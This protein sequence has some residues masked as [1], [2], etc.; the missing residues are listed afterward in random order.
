MKLPKS[1]LEKAKIVSFSPIPEGVLRQLIITYAPDIKFD[2]VVIPEFDREKILRELEDADIVVGDYTFKIPITREMIEHMKRVRLIQ[3][4]STGYDHIDVEAAKEKGIPVANIGGANALSVAEHTIALA[5]LLLKRIIHAHHRVSSGVW[6]QDEMFNLGIYELY[7]KKWGI[8]GLGRIGREV[9]KRVRCFGVKT[10]YYDKIRFPVELER[11]LQVEYRPLNRLLRESDVISIHVPLTNETRHMIS[12]KELRMMKPNA[13]LIN[14]S[15][16]EIVDEV[17]LAK[18]LSERWIM[19]AGVD[20]FS[21]EPIPSDHPL[22]KVRGANLVLTP[23]I[24]G[25]TN[26]A[27]Q[28][29]TITSIDNIVRAI[30]GEELRNVVNM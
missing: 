24:A 14:V 4:P 6:A 17:A 3:Q 12:E 5:L 20:V 19:G 29:I 15:R 11:E 22:L 18:A 28:R 9:A 10:L 23:H 26:E 13:I 27:R 1:P 25:A 30:K 7:D 16:G 21:Q 8:I 2:L